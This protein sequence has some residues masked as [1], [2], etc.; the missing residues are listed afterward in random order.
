[1]VQDVSEDGADQVSPA[2]VYW[3]SLMGAPSTPEKLGAW[4]TVYFAL[5]SNRAGT[6]AFINEMQQAVW[7]VNA[8]LPVAA[9]STMQDINGQSMARTSFTLVMLAIAGIM[10]LALGI[11]GIYG[12]ISYAVSQRTREIGIR[13]ALG[14]Q[15]R[16]GVDDR[17]LRV[18]ADRRWHCCGPWRGGCPCAPHANA[19]VWHS[20]ARSGDVHSRTGCPG[21]CS[22]TGILSAGAPHHGCRSRGSTPSRVIGQQEATPL[23]VWRDSHRG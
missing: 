17:P 21:C 6:Q 13:M 5:R 1:M 22:S 10:A 18:A 8:N 16:T 12:V 19:I 7:S 3:P 11:V 9:I 15:A 23:P 2:T 14:E 4:H 20:P